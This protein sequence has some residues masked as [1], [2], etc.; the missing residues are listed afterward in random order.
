MLPVCLTVSVEL[1]L[2]LR[3]FC[4]WLCPL[5][6][7]YSPISQSEVPEKL[8]VCVGH[9]CYVEDSEMGVFPDPFVP[10]HTRRFPVRV[11]SGQSQ[12]RTFMA[13][14]IFYFSENVS[15]CSPGLPW[16]HNS[17]ASSSQM[18]DNRHAPQYLLYCSN[19]K[20]YLPNFFPDRFYQIKEVSM[21]KSLLFFFF[22][23]F[24]KNCR[25]CLNFAFIS[26]DCNWRQYAAFYWL[27][28]SRAFLPSS[29]G[30]AQQGKIDLQVSFKSQLCYGNKTSVVLIGTKPRNVAS[31][32]RIEQSTS[33]ELT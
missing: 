3:S 29:C 17:L 2:S 11:T 32:N 28:Q 25:I 14:I 33:Y 8:L 30:E 18:T 7:G 4:L 27:A 20:Q 19:W 21:I 26:L 31:W 22:Y 13:T 10:E 1:F 6:V 15:L 12:Q 5:L 24:E 23:S 16:T 9:L